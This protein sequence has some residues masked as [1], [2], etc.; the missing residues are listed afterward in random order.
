MKLL[1][2]GDMHLTPRRPANRID[3]YEAAVLN[4][5]EFIL[6]TAC[7][8]NCKALLQ[9]CDFFDADNPPYGFYVKV[10]KMIEEYGISVITDFGQHDLRMRNQTD[11]GLHALLET[12]ERVIRAS[13]SVIINDVY[14]SCAEFGAA[15]PQAQVGYFNI[16]MTH[17]MV[18][19]AKLWD[20]QKGAIYGSVLLNQYP[21]Y[22]VMVTGDNHQNFFVEDKE[23]ILI[24]AGS[25]MRSTIA[26]I[27]HKPKI[28]ILEVQNKSIIDL[29]EI[30]IPIEP[31]EKVFRLER[32]ERTKA[33]DQNR[34][35]YIAG[36]QEHK[37]Q[38]LHFEDELNHYTAANNIEQEVV[39]ILN[40]SK[41]EKP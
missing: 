19:K 32:V 4:K 22:E 13:R 26:Q 3:D 29:V 2:T 23:R 8:E 37:A 12:S 15:I 5:F 7:E 31:A 17:R 16:L 25:M 20:G 14:V 9:P 6:R 24:N 28:Y 11:T 27:D 34:E 18:V 38:D 1:I 39:Q 36:L 10:Y 30:A 33:A 40:E 21:E 35:A 41:G